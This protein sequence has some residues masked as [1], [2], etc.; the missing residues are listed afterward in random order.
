M[1]A[2]AAE[3]ED[4]A[5][6]HYCSRVSLGVAAGVTAGATAGAQ[7]IGERWIRWRV[8]ISVHDS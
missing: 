3:W 6:Q 5:C 4:V 2:A 1:R 8:I 7:R